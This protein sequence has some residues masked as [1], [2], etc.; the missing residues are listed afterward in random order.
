[1]E[2][3]AKIST[4]GL[5]IEVPKN[6][7]MALGEAMLVASF[8]DGYGKMPCWLLSHRCEI[9]AEHDNMLM[10]YEDS[11][12]AKIAIGFVLI[13]ELSPMVAKKY[14]A[15]NQELSTNEVKSGDQI[16]VLD[17]CCPFGHFDAVYEL[18]MA[19]YK[20]H[21]MLRGLR[22]GKPKDFPNHFYEV[23]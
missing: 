23:Q 21:A 3:R 17:L 11:E 7:V 9:S 2:T 15:R 5:K 13:G 4:Y 14:I 12:D 19:K 1:M 16:W 6:T 18:L 22:D 8:T 10:V 20:D